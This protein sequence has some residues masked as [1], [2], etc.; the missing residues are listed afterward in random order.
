MQM[1]CLVCDFEI[2]ASLLLV[3][4]GL[5]AVSLRNAVGEEKEI[6]KSN[7]SYCY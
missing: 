2:K 7:F 5:K 4:A 6:G 3:S 1:A